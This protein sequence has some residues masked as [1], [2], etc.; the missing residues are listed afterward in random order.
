MRG[1]LAPVLHEY[2]VTFRVMH[3]FA[4]ST[5]LHQVAEETQR[6]SKPLMVF[7]VGDWDPSGLH[8][9]AVDIPA[10]LARYSG[11]AHLLRLALDS[12]DLSDLPSFLAATKRGDPR[13]SWFTAR[14]GTRCW[15]LDALS[16]V[17]LRNRVER[18]I[19]ERID[20]QAWER[21]AIAERAEC[22]SLRSILGSWPGISRQ[23]SKYSERAVD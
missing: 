19:A 11:N 17:T 3:G 18:S 22:D 14:Y 2:G 13:Y 20:W 12:E 21:A 7:Y 23:G 1:T 6:S 5:A 9:S 16:P 8:M 4:S 10:R 15:E